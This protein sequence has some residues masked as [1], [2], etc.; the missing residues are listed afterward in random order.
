MLC[1]LWHLKSIRPFIDCEKQILQER[2]YASDSKN[3]IHYIFS[4][5][6]GWEEQ[7][8]Q[9]RTTW[10][11]VLKSIPPPLRERV[12]W[13]QNVTL[14]SPLIIQ[15]GDNLS[16][17]VWISMW[18]E[19]VDDVFVLSCASVPVNVTVW[20]R[21]IALHLTYIHITDISMVIKLLGLVVTQGCLRNYTF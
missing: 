21:H 14:H 6:S 18:D 12:D 3:L 17:Y 5:P 13:L 15:V 19:H 1:C 20:I 8:V 11:N 4:L 16:K 9:S 2:D 7:N 10:V